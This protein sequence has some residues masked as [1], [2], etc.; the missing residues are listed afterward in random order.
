MS[1]GYTL[2]YDPERCSWHGEV[3]LSDC[4]CEVCQNSDD[5]R[6]RLMIQ[7]DGQPLSAGTRSHRK[8]QRKDKSHDSIK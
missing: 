2:P 3:H 7:R 1:A 8:L 5:Y 6:N 4:D